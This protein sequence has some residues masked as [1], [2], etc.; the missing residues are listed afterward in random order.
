[1]V[2]LLLKHKEGVLYQG[3]LKAVT[4][5]MGRVGIWQETA[6]GEKGEG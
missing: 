3:L 2:F 5:F 6:R 1:M 4:A